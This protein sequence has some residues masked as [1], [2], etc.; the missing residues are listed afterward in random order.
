MRQDFRMKYLTKKENT[1]PNNKNK[2]KKLKY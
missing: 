2:E 1:K